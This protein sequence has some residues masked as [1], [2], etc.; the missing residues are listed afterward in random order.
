MYPVCNQSKISRNEKKQ[1]N[2]NHMLEKN[3]T[4]ETSFEMT[5]GFSRQE[6]WRSAIV[7]SA[8]MT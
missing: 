4:I 8:E 1:K 3:H 7:F 2:V 5:M 6:Y